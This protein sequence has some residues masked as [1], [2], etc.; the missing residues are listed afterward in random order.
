MSEPNK[1]EV[2]KQA[3]QQEAEQ[4]P[5]QA[6]SEA[7]GLDSAASRAAQPPEQ[8]PAYKTLEAQN[9]ARSQEP[10]AKADAAQKSK[11]E[12]QQGAGT[13]N[14]AAALPSKQQMLDEEMKREQQRKATEARLASS[15]YNQADMVSTQRDAMRD[16]KYRQSI[17]A[18][19]PSVPRQQENSAQQ[20]E[21]G[22]RQQAEQAP[23]KA[24]QAE[25]GEAGP[26][27]TDQKQ[28]TQDKNARFRELMNQSAK[29]N[30]AE[31]GQDRGGHSQGR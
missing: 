22:K 15:L 24:R 10:Q 7:A 11:A 4:K 19:G 23:E 16:D 9:E 2:L 21:Q 3:P 20:E 17:R 31:R 18:A 6:K 28:R 25:K 13:D 14:G 29:A 5:Q 8:R 12:H 30:S 26:E 27:M 1:Y